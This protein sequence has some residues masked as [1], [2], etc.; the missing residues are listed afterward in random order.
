M[1]HYQ[2]K[3]SSRCATGA[4]RPSRHEESGNRDTYR[5]S[6]RRSDYEHGYDRRAPRDTYDDRADANRRHEPSRRAPRDTYDDRADTNRRHEPSRRPIDTRRPPNA[7]RAEYSDRAHHT[8]RPDHTARDKYTSCGNQS[9][10]HNGPR[11]RS[12]HTARDEYTSRA[13]QSAPRARHHTADKEHTPIVAARTPAAASA[14]AVKKLAAIKSDAA[15]KKSVANTS[16]PR[17]YPTA[18]TAADLLRKDKSM[19][20]IAMSN[21]DANGFNLSFPPMLINPIHDEDIE[22]IDCND[23]EMVDYDTDMSM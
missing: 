23:I 14:L 2:S 6:E 17:S 18:V 15:V 22:M 19:R 21:A 11:P 4:C 10:T 12:D 1:S 20:D 3:Q 9:G 16:R 5:P 13:N 7:G 8:R